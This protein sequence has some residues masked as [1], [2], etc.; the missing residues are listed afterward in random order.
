M[1]ETQTSFVI[2]NEVNV[3]NPAL[4][5]LEG[6]NPKGEKIH[7]SDHYMMINDEPYFGISG[8]FHYSRYDF[9]KWED[10]IIKMKMCGINIIPTYVIWNHHEE[11]KGSFDWKGSKSLRTFV[12]LC[13]KHNIQSILRIGPFAH[14][15]VRNG[16]FPDWLYGEPCR[17]R[18]NDPNYLIYVERLYNEIGQQIEGLLYKDGGP[19]IGIQL[20]NEFYHSAAPWEFAAGTTDEWVAG[21]EDGEEHIFKLKEIAKEAGL[22]TPIYT[23]TGWGGALAP[24]SEVLPLWGGYAF[25]PW[26]FYDENVKEHPVT[27]EYIYRDYKKPTYNFEP[28]YDPNT[29]P[30]AC[31]EMGGGMTCFYAYRFKLPFQS[32]EAMANIK[33]AGGCNFV[34]YYMF[35][36]GI[37]P[38]GKIT[39]YLNEN[40]TPKMSYDYQAPIGEFGQI[41][42]S[43]KLLKRQHY[44]YKSVENSFSKTKTLLPFNTDQMDPTDVDTL[45]YAFRVNEGK[46][47]VF[48]NNYQD[49]LTSPTKHNV[50]INFEV[51]NKS[52]SIPHKEGMTI[53]SEVSCILP[54]N[55]DMGDIK[56]EYA[57]AQLIKKKDNTYYFFSPDELKPSFRFYDQNI[58]QVEISDGRV[59]HEDGYWFVVPKEGAMTKFT[60]ITN[61]G[62]HINVFNMTNEQSLNF[63]SFD[64]KGYHHAVI[65]EATLLVDDH[66]IRFETE[67]DTVKVKVIDHEASPAFIEKLGGKSEGDNEIFNE[68]LLSKGNCKTFTPEINFL[69]NGK[70][71]ISVPK[72]AFE[73]T[74]ELFLNVDYEGDIG[75]AFLDNELILDNFSNGEIWKI[76]L[77]SLKDRLVNKEIYLV[78]S[79]IKV[80]REVKS[81]SPM[82]ARSE[83]AD[84]NIA[85]IHSITLTN[86]NEFKI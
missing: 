18:S 27:P 20:E 14:G 52:I 77:S 5:N 8:E 39:P 7:F 80:G 35:H 38:K 43:Y 84:E 48:I 57:T 81:D 12:E 6:S 13:K 46:G 25:W 49:H 53:K 82:A 26:A 63:W 61:D 2:P 72:E 36:G 69:D 65:A 75:Y 51:D 17:V 22:I 11:V 3:F 54:F 28:A 34:G 29:I 76:G 47:Y 9:T 21:G 71:L 86:V 19:I 55:F 23:G 74:K 66:Q 1:K 70:A 31:C 68:Y 67:S 15:E 78:I 60:V 62:H 73:E 45:R 59:T 58:S 41:R 83:T 37:N 30:F 33:V 64:W 44:F 4:P 10:E 50:S 24:T 40:A 32:V 85:A 56:L 16:G 42:D 79:P